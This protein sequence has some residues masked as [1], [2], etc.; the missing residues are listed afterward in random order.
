MTSS[1][2]AKGNGLSTWG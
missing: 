1:F 2:S